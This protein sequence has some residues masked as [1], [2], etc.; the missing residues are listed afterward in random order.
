MD[1]Q[2]TFSSENATS[3]RDKLSHFNKVP[4]RWNYF[5]VWEERDFREIGLHNIYILKKK[6]GEYA[7]QK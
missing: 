2:Q 3:S 4:K 1:Y 7:L 6:K 5:I